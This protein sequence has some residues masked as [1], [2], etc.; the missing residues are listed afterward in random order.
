MLTPLQAAVMELTHRLAQKAVPHGGPIVA[1]A[2]R[3]I[4]GA[5]AQLTD[6]QLR[7]ALTFV[8]DEAARLLAIAEAAES[9]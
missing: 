1:A 2:W 9:E 5:V 6:A 3:M 7:E 8:R 4:P